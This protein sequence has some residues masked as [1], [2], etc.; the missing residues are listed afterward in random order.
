MHRPFKV[1]GGIFTA[2]LGILACGFLAWQNFAPMLERANNDDPVPLTILAV[3]GAVGAVIYL[4]YG[5]W[6]SKLAKGIDVS[7]DTTLASPAEAL[8]GHVDNIKED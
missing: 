3:Y 7:D 6:N 5:L 2:I 8:G 4:I 1:P